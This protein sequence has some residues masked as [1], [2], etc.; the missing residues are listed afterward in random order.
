MKITILTA[1]WKRP[2]VLKI[3]I[4][5]IE[6]LRESVDVD[7]VAVGS[8]RD[9]IPEW[10]TFVKYKNMPLSNKWNA[11]LKK[12]KD[13]DYVII[14]GSDDIIDISLLKEMIKV[15]EKGID[16]IYL[17]DFYLYNIK[18]RSGMYWGGYVDKRKGEGSG[19]GRCISKSLLKLLKY[20]LWPNGL[21]R[22]LDAGMM[23]MLS[24]LD[25]SKEGISLKETQSFGIDVKG[26]DNLTKFWLWKNA[27]TIR[28]RKELMRG[29]KT[30]LAT[31]IL[32]LRA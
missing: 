6:L 25:Y 22:G 7:L 4:R 21:E 2:E 31:S 3:F 17:T 26:E 23:E 15:M 16:F 28:V 14:L 1:F 13:S 29:L 8:E 18:S 9:L 24:G 10:A 5:S 30:E 11:G 27:H 12:C 20:K 32:K 19:V